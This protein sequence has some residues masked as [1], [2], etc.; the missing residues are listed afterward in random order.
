MSDLKVV[1]RPTVLGGTFSYEGKTVHNKIQVVW[2]ENK[3]TFVTVIWETE[4]NLWN[5]GYVIANGGYTRS[6]SHEGNQG[7]LYTILSTSAKWKRFKESIKV[8]NN[9]NLTRK[10]VTLVVDSEGI[11]SIY[12]QKSVSTSAASSAI[13]ETTAEERAEM[14]SLVSSLRTIS[15][16]D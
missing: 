8:L 9:N 7:K 15:L 2:M 11:P 6:H 3:T 12:E 10:K 14:E 16:E 1:M 13:A 4:G 5:R